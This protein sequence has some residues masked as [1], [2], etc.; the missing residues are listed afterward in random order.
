MDHLPCR[1]RKRLSSLHVEEAQRPSGQVSPASDRGVER[2]RTAGEECRRR[3]GDEG[4]AVG[5]GLAKRAESSAFCASMA[6]ANEPGKHSCRR[7]RWRR[8]PCPRPSPARRRPG[9][10]RGWSRVAADTISEL[11]QHSSLGLRSFGSRLHEWNIRPSG[12]ALASGPTPALFAVRWTGYAASGSLR[13]A[14][15]R[16][17]GSVRG[18]GE[19]MAGAGGFEPPYGGIKIRLGTLFLLS[20]HPCVS[21]LCCRSG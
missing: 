8:R 2:R 18:L 17:A 14:P 1:R 10:R 20:F 9:W 5:L 12:T 19:A 21:R 3:G 6:A 16:K 11:R 7:R 15:G 4:D 13:A